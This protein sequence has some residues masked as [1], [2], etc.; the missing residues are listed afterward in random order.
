MKLSIL[1]LLLGFVAG[2]G[3]LADATFAQEGNTLRGFNTGGLEKGPIDVDQVKHRLLQMMRKSTKQS[4]MQPTPAPTPAAL[5][6]NCNKPTTIVSEALEYNANEWYGWSC[7]IPM[8]VY[9]CTVAATTVANNA[10]FFQAKTKTLWKKGGIAGGKKYPVTPFED[11][12]QYEENEE[13]C[14]V[15]AMVAGLA[16]I[17]LNCCSA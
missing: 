12:R 13:G 5:V 4:T 2:V 6:C 11:E 8:K 9:D 3:I 10:N 15:Q 14:L 17:T 1:N 16:T 7:P